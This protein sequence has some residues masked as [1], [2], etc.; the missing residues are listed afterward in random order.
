MKIAKMD[1]DTIVEVGSH[2]TLFPNTNFYSAEPNDA[3]LLNNS[4]VKVVTFLSFDNATH[5]SESVEPY[6]SDGEV[7]IRRVVELTTDEKAAKT[8]AAIA[9]TKLRNRAER[10][11]RLADCD[12]VVIK[13]LEAGTSVA[14][15]WVTYRTALRDITSHSNWPDLEYPDMDGTGGDWPTSP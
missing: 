5:K 15:D 2:R 10:D 13:A 7:Y 8:A 3:W 4:C 12:W 6:L 14:S 1:G 11:K 9:E